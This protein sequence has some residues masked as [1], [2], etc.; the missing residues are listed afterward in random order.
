MRV[1]SDNHVAAGGGN[2]GEVGRGRY[3]EPD[4]TIENTRYLVEAIGIGRQAEGG[5]AVNGFGMHHGALD[6]DQPGFGVDLSG[7]LVPDHGFHAPGHQTTRLSNIREQQR[8]GMQFKP[9]APDQLEFEIQLGAVQNPGIH[10]HIHGIGR[11]A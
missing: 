10:C 9:I 11:K 1:G 7:F 5:V 2:V 8:V 6:G 3:R 4:V